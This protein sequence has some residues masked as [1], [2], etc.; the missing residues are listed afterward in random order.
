[1]P[2]E[3]HPKT[4][5]K[6]PKMPRFGSDPIPIPTPYLL[7]PS[8]VFR[9]NRRRIDDESDISD[10]DPSSPAGTILSS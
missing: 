2:S 5:R 9:I 10:E 1:M 6:R 3:N 4:T 7:I 8:R